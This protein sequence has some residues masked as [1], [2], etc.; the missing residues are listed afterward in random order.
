M[1][2]HIFVTTLFLF[3]L[4]SASFAS[5]VVLKNE[6]IINKRAVEKIDTLGLEL[7]EKTGINSYVV[8]LKTIGDKPLVVYEKELVS[9]LEKPY[10]LLSLAKN[11][12]QIDIV[13]SDELKDKFDK[14]QILSPYPW[15]GTIIPILTARKGED[16]YSAALLNGYA[17]MVEQIAYSYDVKLKSAIGNANKNVLGIIRFIFYFSIVLVIGVGLYWRIKRRG[18]TS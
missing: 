2:S 17:D 3:L 16:K 4:H 1:R 15:S 5:L 13:Y 12:Q 18:K 6:D 11:E 7:R 10:A 8:A 9:Q 14:E